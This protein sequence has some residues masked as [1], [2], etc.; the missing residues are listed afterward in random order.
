MTEEEFSVG[1]LLELDV[2]H[3]KTGASFPVR[4]AI[5][6]RGQKAAGTGVGV[7]LIEMDEAQRDAFWKFVNQGDISPLR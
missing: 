2:V 4:G 1:Q 7:E 3:P 6:W 5:R